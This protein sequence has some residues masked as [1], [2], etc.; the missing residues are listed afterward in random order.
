M[1]G[2]VGSV[3]VEDLLVGVLGD[4]V[5]VRR[6]IGHLAPTVLDQQLRRVQRLAHHPVERVDCDADLGSV[7]VDMVARKAV[8]QVVEERGL[9]QVVEPCHVV[10]ALLWEGV[11]Q[12]ERLGSASVLGARLLGAQHNCAVLSPLDDRGFEPVAVDL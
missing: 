2:L 3:R 11:H 6:E 7:G 4:G 5:D 9:V 12:V 8:A 1:V 10:H